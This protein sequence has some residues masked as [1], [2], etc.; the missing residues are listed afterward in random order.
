MYVLYLVLLVA[1]LIGF[2]A[3]LY[4]QWRIAQLMRQH[5]PKQ[6]DIVARPDAGARS[7][8]RTWAR[9]QQVLR[10][11]IPVLFDDPKM[12][13]WYRCW[14]YAPWIAWPCWMGVLLLRFLAPN[15]TL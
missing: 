14:R 13:A 9:F 7:R 6:W 4:A 2:V 5:H 15:A 8:L 10:A 1:G 11:D 12:L 3:H